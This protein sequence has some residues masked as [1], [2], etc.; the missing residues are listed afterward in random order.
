MIDYTGAGSRITPD[1]MKKLDPRRWGF[2]PKVD[3]CYARVVLDGDG[4]IENVTSRA[5]RSLREADDLIGI[6]AGYAGSV[7]HGELEA[8]TEAGNAAATARGWRNLHLFDATEL[9]G[10]S[11]AST[12]YLE[13][14]H[15]L[16]EM[17]AEIERSGDARVE[18]MVRDER[19]RRHDAAGKYAAFVPRDLRRLPIVE[20][21]RGASA[22]LTLWTAH[23]EREEGEGLVAV[24]LD[25]QVGRRGSKRKIKVTDTIDATVMRFDARTAE[26][27]HGGRSFFVG[28]AG[29]EL[30]PGTVVEVKHD[31]RYASGE[32]RFA[33]IV[34]ERRDLPR[35]YLN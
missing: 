16:H 5:G 21:Y 11:L 25:A 2:Q 19:G 14:Y 29:L 8:H 35:S 34:R 6:L 30:A 23:V 3:G 32:P 1:D 33:R 10:R 13:R 12:P 28:C 7:L 4:R 24:R 18:P 9:G 27:A 20:L 22:A 26:L 17:Q 15:A 31:G